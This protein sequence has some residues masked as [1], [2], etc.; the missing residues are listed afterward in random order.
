MDNR[1]LEEA[2]RMI[3]TI[4]V[5]GLVEEFLKVT[6][7]NEELKNARYQTEVYRIA[8]TVHVKE[9]QRLRKI[10]EDADTETDPSTGATYVRYGSYDEDQE[11]LYIPPETLPSIVKLENE[12]KRLRDACVETRLW[13]NTLPGS[14]S[15]TEKEAA[16]E[17]LDEALE[18]RQ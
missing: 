9:L 2:R 8:N 13:L 17:I 7:E 1:I 12:N 3:S 5:E 10:I 11:D 16:I 18:N 15:L 4:G 6:K 14:V